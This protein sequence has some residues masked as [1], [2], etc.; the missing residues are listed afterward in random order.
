MLII[1][2]FLPGMVAH[3]YNF[4]TLEVEAGLSQAPDQPGLRSETCLKKQIPSH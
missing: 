3:K 1:L 2:V 4:S